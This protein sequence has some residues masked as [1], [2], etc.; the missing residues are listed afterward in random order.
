M[1]VNWLPWSLTRSTCRN[2][3]WRV[4]STSRRTKD[5][6]T[7][8]KMRWSFSDMKV[9]LQR[10]GLGH[11][12]FI[13]RLHGQ[14]TCSVTHKVLHC[15]G[16][17]HNHQTRPSSPCLHRNKMEKRLSGLSKCVLCERPLTVDWLCFVTQFRN[18]NLL[19]HWWPDLS[20]IYYEYSYL[21]VCLQFKKSIKWDK[22]PISILIKSLASKNRC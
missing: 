2:A 17:K 19:L 22:S 9:T 5:G 3:C 14:Y 12:Y 16:R 8:S 1:S 15:K 11:F 21:Q 7:A 6:F 13:L 20:F 18:M 4:K 10:S